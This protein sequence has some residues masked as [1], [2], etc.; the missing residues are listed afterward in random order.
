MPGGR[1]IINYNY[2]YQPWGPPYTPTDWE[3]YLNQK[4][5]LLYCK[6]ID[7]YNGWLPNKPCHKVFE[8]YGGWRHI[9]WY[10]LNSGV[11]LMLK[12]YERKQDKIETT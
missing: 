10:D 1:E 12:D 5:E 6:Y 4:F 7:E 11:H 2:M 9:G 3:S 8:Y